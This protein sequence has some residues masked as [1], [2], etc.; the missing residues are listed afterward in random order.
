MTADER[1]IIEEWL[2]DPVM[3]FY[4]KRAAEV[5]ARL[6]ADGKLDNLKGNS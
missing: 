4:S 6:I 3:A 5:I 1:E 2:H